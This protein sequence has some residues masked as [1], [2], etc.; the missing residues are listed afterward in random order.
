MLIRQDNQDVTITV[1]TLIRHVQCRGLD[2]NPRKIQGITISK[3]VF[4]DPML[5]HVPQNKREIITLWT[6]SREKGSLMPGNLFRFCRKH[7]RHLGTLYQSICYMTQKTTAWSGAH[8][9]KKNVFRSN[10]KLWCK[11]LCFGG[12]IHGP[13]DV[14]STSGVKKCFVRE[15][16]D[17]IPQK[18]TEVLTLTRINRCLP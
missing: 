18:E 15:K 5:G 13:Y 4:M 7:I 17:I 11:H 9:K 1:E 6:S 12:D 2:T 16:K 14:G 10:S 3:N 8:S